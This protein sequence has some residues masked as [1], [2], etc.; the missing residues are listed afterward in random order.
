[1]ISMFEAPVLSRYPFANNLGTPPRSPNEAGIYSPSG[2]ANSLTLA[3]VDSLVGAFKADGKLCCKNFALMWHKLD[4][5]LIPEDEKDQYLPAVVGQ[6]NPLWYEGPT[7]CIH[8]DLGCP[9][10]GPYPAV[11]HVPSFM[12]PKRA[13]KVS[14]RK[15][16]NLKKPKKETKDPSQRTL[17]QSFGAAASSIQ[18]TG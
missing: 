5:S 8:R 16:P 15:D 14:E 18:L 1:M 9:C 17:E 10:Y 12:T 2:L 4:G 3:E 13:G 6:L 11:L 7:M